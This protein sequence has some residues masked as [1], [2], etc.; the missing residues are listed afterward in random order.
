VANEGDE[1]LV[2]AY[3]RIPN[4]VKVLLSNPASYT[5]DA[6]AKALQIV[7]LAQE[8]IGELKRFDNKEGDERT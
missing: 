8:C 2:K 6:A 4:E 7:D 1:Q 3:D 5:G